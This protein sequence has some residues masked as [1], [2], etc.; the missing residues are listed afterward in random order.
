LEQMEKAKE[1][2]F[3][4]VSGDAVLTPRPPE[5]QSI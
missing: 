1:D 4:L 5:W 2:G 3:S